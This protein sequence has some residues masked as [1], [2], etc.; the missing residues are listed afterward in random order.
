MLLAEIDEFAGLPGVYHSLDLI[1]KL[2]TKLKMV[3]S[4]TPRL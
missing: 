3:E 4:E 1:R 2:R